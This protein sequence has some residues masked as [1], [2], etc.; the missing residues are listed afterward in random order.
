[1]CLTRIQAAF[2]AL[3]PAPLSCYAPTL[4][5]SSRSCSTQT[6]ANPRPNTLRSAG[7]LLAGR[8]R[9]K[10]H[11]PREAGS[12]SRLPSLLSISLLSGVHL[13]GQPVSSRR[14][15]PWGSHPACITA[16]SQGAWSPSALGER[17]LPEQ[18]HNGPEGLPKAFNR[19]AWH[20]RQLSGYPRSPSDS[21]PA[22][23]AT[24][25]P[26]LQPP[27]L[28]GIACG[29]RCGLRL[30]GEGHHRTWLP[31]DLVTD[32]RLWLGSCGLGLQGR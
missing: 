14:A 29:C 5:A 6:Y 9:P 15:G 4:L 1:M 16:T 11:R 7:S 8:A 25:L 31:P 20:L 13:A 17:Q 30:V 22:C 28:I 3:P 21:C 23:G 32:N 26:R 2:H 24:R 10:R 19:R 18:M 12:P 27:G